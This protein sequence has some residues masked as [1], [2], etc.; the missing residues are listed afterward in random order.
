MPATV[1]YKLSEE[2]VARTPADPDQFYTVTQAALRLH[3]HPL[4]VNRWIGS[5]RLRAYRIGPK[6]VR[7]KGGDLPGQR[8]AGVE[9]PSH[10]TVGRAATRLQV[11]PA[12]IWRWIETGQLQ[13]QRFGPK[14][15]RITPE[16][17]ATIIRPLNRPADETKGVIETMQERQPRPILTR[18]RANPLTED[19]VH[20]RLEALKRASASRKAQLERRGGVPY[21]SSAD[22]IRQAREEMAERL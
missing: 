15:T 16:A 10:Y 11:D 5:G 1:S 7:I 13:A 9:E 2:Q 6:A 17:L 20:R 18:Q 19:E 14:T 4:T 12:T 8:S 22:L 3:V 21:P